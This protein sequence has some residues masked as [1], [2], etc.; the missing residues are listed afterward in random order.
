MAKRA[1][2]KRLDT[3][4]FRDKKGRWCFD[5]VL[6]GI[7]YKRVVGPSKTETRTALEDFKS[8]KRREIEAGACQGK[9]ITFGDYASI[10]LRR[11][12]GSKETGWKKRSAK[13]DAL[14][15][16]LHLSPFFDK[17]KLTQVRRQ[18]VE[19]YIEKRKGDKIVGR[20]KLIKGATINR[21][22]ALLRT[23]FNR[24]RRDGFITGVPFEWGDLEKQP[25]NRRKRLLSDAERE[26]L[27]KAS[28]ECGSYLLP[29]V[30]IALKTGLRSSE[31]LS[32]RWEQVDLERRELI[33]CRKKKRLSD[34]N[35]DRIP[36]NKD[37]IT[38]LASMERKSDFVFYNAE[39]RANVKSVKTAFK[40][41]CQRAKIKDCRIHDLRRTAAT[42]AKERGALLTNIQRMLGHSSLTM[43]ERYLGVVP[44][45]FRRDVDLLSDDYDR[46]SAA[47]PI[48]VLAPEPV[49]T[50]NQDV[51]E[52]NG[53]KF[54]Q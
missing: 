50:C 2:K 36:V 15:L 19:D 12:L 32:L 16:R 39:T 27:L 54:L 31:I 34:D 35:E 10:Y 6:G 45:S 42:L 49:Q 24:A 43:T 44:D 33:V 51:I 1:Y 40:T 38:L 21:E 46:S 41:A 7:R 25:E 52:A 30:I 48:P 11:Y 14:A 3:N 28:A 26:A 17:F 47:S 22:I 9:A 53:P 13:Q 37:V 4:L 18:N 5:V 29:F 20:E 8:D 23:M